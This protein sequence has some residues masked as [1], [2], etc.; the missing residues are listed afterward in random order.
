VITGKA[1][2]AAVLDS[3]AEVDSALEVLAAALL[4]ADLVLLGAVLLDA[5]FDPDPQPASI[6]LATRAATP[7]TETVAARTFT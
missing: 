4:E 3:A 7:A 6:T 1:V 2:S 5:V